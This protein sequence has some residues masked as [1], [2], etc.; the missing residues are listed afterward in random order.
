MLPPIPAMATPCARTVKMVAA[1]DKA[2]LADG[3]LAVSH[4]NQ[5]LTMASIIERD[6][7]AERDRVVHR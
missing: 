3:D 5:L 1:V 6:G 2:W 7:A 4:K